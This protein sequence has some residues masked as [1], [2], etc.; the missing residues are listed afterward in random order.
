MIHGY[1]QLYVVHRVGTAVYITLYLGDMETERDRGQRLYSK[2]VFRDCIQ[3]LYS[4][5]V[6]KDSIQRLYSKKHGVWD[7]M[8][9]YVDF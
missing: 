8:S 9:P 4:E 7:T 2:T 5:T 6:F 1:L 3:R